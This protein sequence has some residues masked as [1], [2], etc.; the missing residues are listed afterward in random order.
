MLFFA[1]FAQFWVKNT[2]M[3]FTA[4]FF[5][6]K[7]VMCL[8]CVSRSLRFLK[9]QGLSFRPKAKKFSSFSPWVF[10]TVFIRHQRFNPKYNPKTSAKTNLQDNHLNSWVWFFRV[11]HGTFLMIL[12]TLK[13]LN[14]LQVYFLADAA[15]LVSQSWTVPFASV[16]MTW[17]PVGVKSA[18]KT[19]ESK[20]AKVLSRVLEEM[21]HRWQHSSSPPVR[22]VEA[23]GE[24]RTTRTPSREGWTKVQSL[25]PAWNRT[26][27]LQSKLLMGRCYW[28]ALWICPPPWTIIPL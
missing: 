26:W 6:T 8:K 15:L 5:W 28:K 22:R 10:L 20:P 13:L 2:K 14:T 4:R 19:V 18:A 27:F 17:D 3:P 12:E 16:T 11:L 7:I 9:K 23:S 21:S 1:C 25:A 24:K